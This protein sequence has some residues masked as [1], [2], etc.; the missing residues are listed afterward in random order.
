MSTRNAIL[1]ALVTTLKN[2]TTGNGFNYTITDV[3][4]KF[5]WY[6]QIT[7]FPTLM[8][9]GGDE[10][11]EDEMGNY[12]LSDLSVKIVGYAKDSK[13]PEV[14]QCNLIEDVL[15]CIDN[16]SYNSNK[17]KMR[18]LGIETDEGMLHSAGDGISMFVLNLTF[19]YSF[20]RSSP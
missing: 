3:V 5:V 16:D 7:R 17:K 11:F 4:R 6:D 9:L 14:A 10:P 12:S 18:P 15:K 20:D 19:K 2:I 1:A 13:E 8:V